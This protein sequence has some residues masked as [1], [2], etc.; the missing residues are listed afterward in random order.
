MAGAPLGGP[1]VGP[2]VSDYD[3]V[4]H[5]ERERQNGMQHDEKELVAT[6]NL[7][8]IQRILFG[9]AEERLESSLRDLAARIDEGDRRI[10][11]RLES[12]E[13]RVEQLVDTERS[14]RAQA[15]A[16]LVAELGQ[17]RAETAPRAAIADALKRMAGE[18]ASLES[19]AEPEP[20][21][22]EVASA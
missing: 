7:E 10:A 19:A 4:I 11:E 14:E 12:L 5:Y 22:N 20:D 13:K 17:V 21:S 3:R 16:G 9:D 2:F 6:R 1:V 8:R 18:L 15:F